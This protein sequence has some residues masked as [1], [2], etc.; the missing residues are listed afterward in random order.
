[1]AWSC[2]RLSFLDDAPFIHPVQ[3]SHIAIS[4]LFF[5]KRP[6]SRSYGNVFA[7]VFATVF[8]TACLAAALHGAPFCAAS[9]WR[10]AS[11]QPLCLVMK[12]PRDYTLVFILLCFAACFPHSNAMGQN[13]QFRGSQSHFG[14]GLG[15]FTYHGRIDLSDTRS[16]SNF[17]RSSDPAA[18]LF[19]SFPVIRD[20]LFFR[21]MVGLSNFSAL[22]TGGELTNNE[23]LNRE[24]FWFEPQV[25]YTFLE[26]SK[27]LVLP[28]IYT[29]FGT[30]VADPFG[31]TTRRLDQP[32]LGAPG[33]DRSVF[34]LPL[35]MGIDYPVSPKFSVFADV[36]FRLNFNYVGRND[37]GRQPHNTSLVLFGFRMNMA[38]IERVVEEV[39]PVD[40]PDPMPIPPYSP[41][42]PVAE[43]PENECLLLEMNALV[44]P[45]DSSAGLSSEMID[46][47]DENVEALAASPA[48]CALIE[49]YTDGADTEEEALAS[50]RNRATSVFDFYTNEGITSDRLAIRPYGTALPCL[51]KE[52][53]ECAIHRRVESTMVSCNTF[54]G[55]RN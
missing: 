55:Y 20:R 15:V 12:S 2:R 52:D 23:F 21:G 42:G 33:P 13:T 24:L 39:P 3:L 50:S 53:P 18:V 51:R 7:A 37:G 4:T 38:T 35:G 36:S 8:A 26:G 16:S 46:L 9:C 34:T 48:C 22:G 45:A 10:F 29:G 54:P 30:L 17:T 41:P 25:V 11:S 44:F 40:L 28:Y 27:S 14:A 19:G 49:G 6:G 1:M 43:Y 5:R 31:G 47:L 32:D